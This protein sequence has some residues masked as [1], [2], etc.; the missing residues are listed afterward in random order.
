MSD[1]KSTRSPE[2]ENPGETQSFA[3]AM[4][5]QKEQEKES[6]KKTAKVAAKGAAMY[7]GGP[8]AGAAVDMAANTK[9][10]EKII[11]KG[12]E[13]LNKVPGVGKASKKLDDAGVLDKADQA[14]SMAGSA[15]GGAG[16][17]NGAANGAAASG[18]AASA[19]T[20]ANT[21]EAAKA[22]SGAADKGGS[23]SSGGDSSFFDNIDNKRKKDSNKDENGEEKERDSVL[24]GKL[25]V[26]MAVKMA[27]LSAVPFILLIVLILIIITAIGGAINDFTDAVSISKYFDL[28]TGDNSAENISDDAKKFIERVKEV[29]D[30]YEKNEKTVDPLLVMAVYHVANYHNKDI[31]YNYMTK[32]RIRAVA[33]AMF[34]ENST[35][36]SEEA[37]RKELTKTIFKNY[38]PNKDEATREKYTNEV[39]EYI[40][41][42]YELIGYTPMTLCAPMG[43]CSYNIKG[44]YIYGRGNITKNLNIT[45]LKIR[46]M[47][48]GSGNGH[49]YGGTF[50]KAMANEELVDF[51]KYILGVAYQ[52]I[53]PGA[54]E[55]AFKAQMVAA[56]SYIL[57]RPTV[58]GGWR[59][60]Q[61]ENG[62]WILQTA[63]STQD[64]VYCDPDKGCSSADGQWSMVHSGLTS[65][66]VLKQPMPSNSKLRSLAN[67]TAG[68]VVV[69][70]QG[71][72]VYT[73]YTSTQQNKMEELA[74]KGL[75]YKQILLE[76]YNGNGAKN[77]GVSGT[78]KMTCNNTEVTCNNG[79]SGDIASWRQ[80]RGPWINIPL[81]NSHNTIRSAGCL[82]TSIAIQMARS[83][84]PINTTEEFNPGVF[85]QFLNRNGG[86][87]SGGSLTDYTLAT[88]MAPN[89]KYV[90]STSVTGYSQDQKYN[91]LVDLLNKGYYVVAEVK[92]GN[93]S[94]QHWVAVISASNGQVTMVDPAS[95]STSMW[96][97]YPSAG[98]SRY[99]YYK[100]G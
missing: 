69:N 1:Y 19:Q 88:K 11:N 9:A 43:T 78:E 59:T 56:R 46:L 12:G 96:Q 70:S 5:E 13:A 68:E 86:F 30:E 83:G 33:A 44:F 54:S 66:R 29:K 47:E 48:S 45:N 90:G 97:K 84:V 95:D 38:F 21:T 28:P 17:A 35:S 40:K 3:S 82:V 98:T 51:E 93:K 23:S 24:D 42:Y 37:F 36:Y 99:V 31:D 71:Y 87:T 49:N 75:N 64:Q 92:L 76:I 81:G 25:K 79:V 63:N 50:G 61:Q 100:V 62:Q 94:G 27:A 14:L 15:G 34:T 60:L 55:E 6:S 80:I 58:M 4:H 74:K 77:L 73:P 7:F 65:G 32:A 2:T 18:G 16:A 72:I 91:T 52:E 20:A 53:G 89:F 10:G 85:V 57:A 39:F 67:E 26:P 41:D 22:S 8:E